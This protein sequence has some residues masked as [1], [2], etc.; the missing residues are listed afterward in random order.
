M[1][2]KFN[3]RVLT[4]MDILKQGGFQVCSNV[5]GF[6]NTLFHPYLMF[7]ACDN[8]EAASLASI[9]SGQTFCPCRMCECTLLSMQTNFNRLPHGDL[10]RSSDKIIRALQAKDTALLRDL[11]V[12]ANV[13]VRSHCLCECRLYTPRP[14]TF[15]FL[16]VWCRTRFCHIWISLV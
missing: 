15:D 14:L 3:H 10:L 7:M 6:K 2:N 13:H 8:K 12:H 4:E 9:K 11:F 16:F 1:L 5:A